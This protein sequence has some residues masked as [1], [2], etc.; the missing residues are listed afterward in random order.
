LVINTAH[1]EHAIAVGTDPVDFFRIESAASHTR[2]A[3]KPSLTIVQC[4]KS[5]C[6]TLNCV[7]LDL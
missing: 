5:D 2:P 6:L 7:G 4:R 3:E 1:G